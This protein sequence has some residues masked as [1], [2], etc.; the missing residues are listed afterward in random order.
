MK[1]RSVIHHYLPSARVIRPALTRHLLVPPGALIWT[2]LKTVL[3]GD[4]RI[5]ALNAVG[6]GLAAHARELL[7]LPRALC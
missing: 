2:E 4:Q 5:A 3:S 1:P 7:V 6:E